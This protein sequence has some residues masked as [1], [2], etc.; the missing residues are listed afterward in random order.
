MREQ[1]NGAPGTLVDA[2]RGSFAASLRSPDG[3][4]APIALLLRADNYPGRSV[5][6]QLSWPV[7]SSAGGR[8]RF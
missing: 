4:A 3:V 7:R 5:Q 6:R 2:L 8:R 1:K